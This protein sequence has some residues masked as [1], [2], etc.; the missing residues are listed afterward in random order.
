LAHATTLLEELE[1]SQPSITPKEQD[2]PFV[3]CTTMADDM[4]S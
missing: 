1:N 2:Y 4:K 3:E